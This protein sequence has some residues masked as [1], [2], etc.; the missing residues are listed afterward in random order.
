MLWNAPAPSNVIIWP[1]SPQSDSWLLLCVLVF[2]LSLCPFYLTNDTQGQDSEHCA[3]L[4][5]LGLVRNEKNQGWFFWRVDVINLY[6]NNNFLNFHAI[7][8]WSSSPSNAFSFYKGNLKIYKGKYA[9]GAF[10]LSFLTHWSN[11]S[12]FSTRLPHFHW[13]F[14]MTYVC[15]LPSVMADI[16]WTYFRCWI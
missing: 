16:L 7:W 6:I 4:G 2:Y 13:C 9:S 10:W 5:S 14:Y 3:T 15:H 1:H 11:Q 12:N 8:W